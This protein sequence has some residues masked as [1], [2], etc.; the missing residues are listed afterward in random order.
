M[1]GQDPLPLLS[2]LIRTPSP[3]GEERACA[4][5]LA[6]WAREHG[7]VASVDDA[8]CRIECGDPEARPLLLLA[9]HLDTVPAGDG[10]TVDPFAATVRGG[11]LIGRGAVDAKGAVAAMACATARAA[12]ERP[13]RRGR[14]VMLAS[15][16]EETRSPSLPLAL[17]RLGGPV[18]AAVIGEPTGLDPCVAQRGLLVLRLTW[19]GEQLH[20]GWAAERVPTPRMAIV[21]AAR[22]V[23]ALAENSFEREHVLLGRVSVTPTRMRAG[24]P[25]A[26]SPASAEVVLDVRS[27]PAYLHDEIV[28]RI[29]SVSG[30]RVEVVSGHRL[31]VETPADSALLGACMRA[32]PGS[33]PFGSPTAS[34]WIWLGHTDVIKLGP[35]D[36]RRSHTR[37]EAICIE[38][39]RRG[40]DLY[41][42]LIAEYSG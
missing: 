38:E 22:G 10:W 4:E 41:A 28:E 23:V 24:E 34:D 7:L 32:A 37:D 26:T 11:E 39:L 20:A 5:L 3:S 16:R 9:S 8:A 18:D 35:G 40:A 25:G 19:A 27:T 29:E 6:E 31:P 36:S 17:E 12:A 15:Y 14:V 21:E 1:S 2:A 30:A 13:P 33:T 42:R